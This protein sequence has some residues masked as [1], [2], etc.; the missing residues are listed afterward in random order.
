VYVYICTP[1]PRDALVDKLLAIASTWQRSI[2]KFH[3]KLYDFVT[4]AVEKSS[5]TAFTS[6]LI[7]H[8]PPHLPIT[9]HFWP[10]SLHNSSLALLP[11]FPSSCT[12][13]SSP[14]SFSPRFTILVNISYTT[15]A[16]A[17]AVCSPT[18]S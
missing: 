3:T 10:P 2:S 17:S 9:S 14:L 6:Q 16:P 15:C 11:I 1:F 8:T 18:P 12:L 5:L 4:A 13:T 7:L